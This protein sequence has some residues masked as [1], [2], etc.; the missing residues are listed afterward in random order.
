[1]KKTFLLSLFFIVS[2]NLLAQD[3]GTDPGT[4]TSPEPAPRTTHPNN[5]KPSNTS[6]F[7]NRL[8]TGG[9]IGMQFGSYTY[10]QIA[11]L[12]GFRATPDLSIGITGKYIYYNVND[13]YSAYKYETNTYGGGF[14]TRYNVMEE[15]FLHGEYEALSL[16]VPVS[17]YEM[18]RRIVSALFLGGGYRQFFGS[19]SSMNIMILFDAIQDQY[20]PYQNPI[21]RIGFDFGL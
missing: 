10:V 17:P 18:N 13:S 21:F 20:S 12:L 11:P 2:L 7:S 4:E 14:F 16:E 15:I 1:M 9:D 19:Y 6:S 3:P 5:K 8:F